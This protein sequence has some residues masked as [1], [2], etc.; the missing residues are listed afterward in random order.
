MLIY[1]PPVL[2]E[3]ARICKSHGALLIADEVMTGWGRTGTL[4][5]C[6]QADIVPRH[7]NA[8]GCLV[9]PLGNTIY[10][11]PPYCSTESEIG[12]VYDVIAG[13]DPS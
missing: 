9:R 5:A 7:I 12:A 4:Y 11:M 8:R 3:M 13:I 10:L 2:A 6:E 1:E